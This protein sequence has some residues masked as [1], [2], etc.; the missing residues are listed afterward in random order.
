MKKALYKIILFALFLT[1][2]TSCNSDETVT[3]NPELTTIILIRHAEQLN[4]DPDSPLTPKGAKRADDLAALLANTTVDAVYT[5]PL[6]RSLSTVQPL[7]AQKGLIPVTYPRGEYLV[8][9]QQI[10]SNYKGKTVLICG[11]PETVPAMLNLL[12][13]E[14]KYMQ[15]ADDDY[16]H[17]Y[18][19]ITERI[20]KSEV[21]VKTYGEE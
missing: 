7:C 17:I 10:T 19:S 9:L 16:N 18:Y 21:L 12:V 13:G 15:S 4:L 8:A 1:A 2:I 20:G 6:V 3:V 5:T 14:E 11:H